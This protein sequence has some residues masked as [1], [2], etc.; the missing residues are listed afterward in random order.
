MS[1]TRPSGE[2]VPPHERRKQQAARAGTLERLTAVWVHTCRAHG[3]PV[4]AVV[5]QCSRMSQRTVYRL[6]E[7]GER[8]AQRARRVSAHG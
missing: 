2:A 7:R 6:A 5:Q 1:L 4:A 8:I 3:I